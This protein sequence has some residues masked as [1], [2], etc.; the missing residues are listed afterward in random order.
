VASDASA[1]IAALDA[2]LGAGTPIPVA[3]IRAWMQSSSIEVQGYLFGILYE[4]HRCVF[5][6]PTEQEIRDFMRRYLERCLVEDHTNST[7][8]ESPYLAAHSVRAWF[9]REWG[10]NRA[11]AGEIRDW[12]ASICRCGDQRVREAVLLG[13]LEHLFQ[14]DAIAEYFMTWERDPML[15]PL[16][17]EARRLA[18]GF[19]RLD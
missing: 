2:A 1:I 19:R 11:V 6:A 3:G 13:T 4:G 14:D 10:R 12:L 9:S 5:E 17:S 18:D 7:Y 15:S 16:V 8:A